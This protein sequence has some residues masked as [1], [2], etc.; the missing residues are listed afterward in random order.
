MN[1][2]AHAP[3]PGQ[4][5]EDDAKVGRPLRAGGAAGYVEFE[6]ETRKAVV[7]LIVADRV[8]V[9]VTCENARG[10]EDAARIAEALDLKKLDATV[11]AAP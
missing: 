2:G 4:P 5:F 8:L 1:H 7:N 3:A 9:T 6:K 11:R 10:P